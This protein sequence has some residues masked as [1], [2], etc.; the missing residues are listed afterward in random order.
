MVTTLS[1]YDVNDRY[2]YCEKLHTVETGGPEAA[3]AWGSAEGV[4]A[5]VPAGGIPGR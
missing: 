4:T 2:D 1:V 5:G 3:I